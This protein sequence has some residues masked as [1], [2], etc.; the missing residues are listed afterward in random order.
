MLRLRWCMA[1]ATDDTIQ[2][3]VLADNKPVPE[4]CWLKSAMPY[5]VTKPQWV[6]LCLKAS[7]MTHLSLD[8]RTPR[9]HSATCR[10]L[11]N[12]V[13]YLAPA[14]DKS[15]WGN[16]VK[17]QGLHGYAESLRRLYGTKKND[18]LRPS[19]TYMYNFCGNLQQN[20]FSAAT[21]QL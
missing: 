16:G 9:A 1:L 20:T 11:Q 8:F 17:S 14:G 13:W 7:N 10:P 3:L 18:S 5:S 4:Q 15:G 12:V 19:G 2:V 21:K 6:K